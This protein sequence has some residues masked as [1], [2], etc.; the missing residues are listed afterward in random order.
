MAASSGGRAWLEELKGH[1]TVVCS[2]M[3]EK[4]P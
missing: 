2:F 1:L 4:L 3:A